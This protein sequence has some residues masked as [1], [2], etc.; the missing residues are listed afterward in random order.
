[1]PTKEVCQQL[2]DGVRCSSPGIIWVK[3]KSGPATLVCLMHRER[4]K[5]SWA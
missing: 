2:Q 4:A 1:M 5:R 3:P